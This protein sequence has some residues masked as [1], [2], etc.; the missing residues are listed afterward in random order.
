MKRLHFLSLSLLVSLAANA[1]PYDSSRLITLGG[2]ATETAFALGAGERIVAID[3]S[4]TFPPQVRD[5]PQVG[6]IRAI[7]PEGVLAQSPS[8]IIA[9]EDL[10]PPPAAGLLEKGGVDVV[11]VASAKD[12]AS[13]LTMI[14]EVGETLGAVER[15]EALNT[16]LKARLAEAAAL[17]RG[18]D[19]PEAVFILSHFGGGRAAGAGTKAHGIMD[20]AGAENIFSHLSGYKAVSEEDIL[21]EN[22]DFILIGVMPEHADLDRDELLRHANLPTV[23]HLS[24]IEVLGLDISYYLSFGPRTGQAALDL[25]R[26]L[27]AAR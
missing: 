14:G 11:K 12:K 16:N 7:N 17:S 15:A 18:R 6:Y 26:V 23:I 19:K 20:L 9:T 2:P 8:L 5:L 13:L 25:A 22:P 24:G 10:G 21:K 3:Q 1:T 4:S 27:Y